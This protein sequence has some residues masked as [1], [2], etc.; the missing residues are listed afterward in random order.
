MRPEYVQRWQHS[1]GLARHCW[2]FYVAHMDITVDMMSRPSYLAWIAC[3]TVWDRLRPSEQ[4]I[5]RFFH[6][7][8]DAPLDH[9]ASENGLTVDYCWQVLKSAWQQWAI[10]RGIAD[11]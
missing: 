2:R 6:A 8:R 10:E 3:N 9:Y 7:S 5:V 11:E 4:D 1:E